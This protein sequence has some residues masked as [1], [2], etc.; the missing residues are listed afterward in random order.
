MPTQVFVKQRRSFLATSG[1]FLLLPAAPTLFAQP[2]APIDVHCD[3]CISSISIPQFR[4]DSSSS[5]ITAILV[6]NLRRSGAF[7]LIDTNQEQFPRIDGSVT[8]YGANELQLQVRLMR[9]ATDFDSFSAKVTR[10][11]IRMSAHIIADR[12][13]KVLTKRTQGMF[14]S[15]LAYIDKRA[16][17]LGN[18]YTLSISDSDGQRPHALLRSSHPIQSPTWSPNGKQILYTSFDALNSNPVRKPRLWVIDVYTGKRQVLGDYPGS[19]GFGAWSPDGTRVIASFSQSGETKL[20]ELD[21][22][23]PSLPARISLTGDGNSEVEPSISP[24]GTLYFCADNRGVFAIHQMDRRITAASPRAV[25]LTKFE[26][27]SPN[28]SKDGTQLAFIDRS[29]GAQLCVMDLSTRVI[30][31][32]AGARQAEAPSFS[33]NGRLIVFSARRRGYSELR[34]VSLDA[35]DQPPQSITQGFGASWGPL[36]QTA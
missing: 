8:A 2:L 23:Q 26:S 10:D 11:Q 21:L 15:K 28:V 4:G 18:Q 36:L 3:G 31:R 30:T 33:P 22:T 29:A 5:E 25:Q 20:Y 9:S 1:A 35:P 16:S 24:N 7:G 13:Y 14:A 34:T 19:A 6:A 12:I 17:Q 27:S 32:F